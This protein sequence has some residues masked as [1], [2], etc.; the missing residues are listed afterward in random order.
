MSH[1][2]MEL[3]DERPSVDL[4]RSKGKTGFRGKPKSS[5]TVST[6]TFDWSRRIISLAIFAAFAVAVYYGLT[7]VF[8]AFMTN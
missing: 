7:W 3:P 4:Q 1:E 6:S 2:K 5:K 8:D